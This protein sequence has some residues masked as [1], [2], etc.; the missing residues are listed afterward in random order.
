MPKEACPLSFAPDTLVASLAGA[1]AIAQLKPGDTV[2]AYDP[3]T[4]ETGTHT[5]SDVMVTEDPATET[6]VTDL[7]VLDTTPNHPFF[8]ADRGWVDAGSLTIGEHLR[9]ATGIDAVVVSFTVDD[10]PAAMW[11]ITVDGAHTFFVGT[12]QVLVHNCSP[13][14]LDQD[15]L[16][17]LAKAAKRS[18]LSTIDA[19]TLL[20][21]AE[22]YGLDSKGGYIHTHDW[23]GMTP[24]IHIGPVDHI[25]VSLP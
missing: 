22:E 19:Q 10:H 12:G 5:V 1:V 8:T 13:F 16:V 9:T 4:G 21:W 14:S 18:G 7:G 6:L 17:Q 23:A 2:L 11:D 3:K 20:D 24:H 15:A 25:P